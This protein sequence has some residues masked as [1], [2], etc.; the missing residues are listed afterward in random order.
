MEYLIV[1]LLFVI[2]LK[3][4]IPSETISESAKSPSLSFTETMEMYH[5]I[6]PLSF[7]ILIL[8]ALFCVTVYLISRMV[9]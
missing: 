8:I 1:L 7:Q 4:S 2:I 9:K 3:V 6:V 5:N